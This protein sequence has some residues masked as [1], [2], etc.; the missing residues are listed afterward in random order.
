MRPRGHFAPLLALVPCGPLSRILAHRLPQIR[1]IQ[2]RMRLRYA[3]GHP[4]PCSCVGIQR[5]LMAALRSRQR[6]FFAPKS[7]AH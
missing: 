5:H 2:L 6:P 7:S 1:L 3:L 4:C